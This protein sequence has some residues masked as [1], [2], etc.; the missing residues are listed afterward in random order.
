MD[1]DNHQA[2][3]M[4]EGEAPSIS[5]TQRLRAALS[6]PTARTLL[7]AVAFLLLVL[8][9]VLYYQIWLPPFARFLVVSDPLQP[10]DAVV[11][12]GGGGPQRV[13]GGVEVFEEG[14]AP[15]FV[16]TNNWVNMPGVRAEYADLMRIEAM[17]QGVPEES[18]V[19]ARDRAR[20]TYEEAL[21][22][23]PLVE[24]R[25]WSSLIVVTDPFHTRRAQR[26]FRDVFRGTGVQVWVHAVNPSWYD[27][28]TWWQDN[29]SLRET[30]T[31]YLK[32]GLYLAG[33]K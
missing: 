12:L 5:R 27:P 26:T 25:G 19:A 13:A 3:G 20:T 17:W 10:A 31:E 23:R 8:L 2:D 30:W 33:Y 22:L 4:S 29:D 6:T 1:P 14:Y 7:V 11:V 32:L 21:T 18:I 15:W 16:V 28:E 9:L 24:G